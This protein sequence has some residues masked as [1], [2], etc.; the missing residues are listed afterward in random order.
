L[1][2]AGMSR[3]EPAV[4]AERPLETPDDSAP[5]DIDF[6]QMGGSLDEIDPVLPPVSLEAGADELTREIARLRG[7]IDERPSAAGEHF[8]DWDIPRTGARHDAASEPI[9]LDLSEPEPVPAAPEQRA[10]VPEP[11]AQP[12]PVPPAMAPLTLPVASPAPLPQ[13]APAAAPVAVPVASAPP[14]TVLPPP[15]APPSGG[16]RLSLATAFSALLAAE[17]SAAGGAAP[18]AAAPAAAGTPVSEAAIEE[19]VHRVVTRMTEDTVRRIVLE[20]AERLI[21]EEIEKIKLKP[22]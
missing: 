10:T 20:T 4:A 15:S 5:L 12:V 17:Q 22:D 16:S 2:P 18:R 6:S 9:A 3:A 13:A 7:P 1:W 8:G 11:P 14:A 19:M 21:R